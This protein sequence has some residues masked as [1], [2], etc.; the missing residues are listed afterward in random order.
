MRRILRRARLVAETILD[1]L[2]TT[3]RM[4]R[5]HSAARRRRYQG[6]RLG[7]RLGAVRLV[8]RIVRALGIPW[9]CRRTAFTIYRALAREGT[10]ARLC[11]GI[12]KSRPPGRPYQGHVW[13]AREPRPDV[14]AGG[15]DFPMVIRY[16]S[17]R[18]NPGWRRG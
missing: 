6:T 11:F 5:T 3:F 17:D 8:L 15:A 13:V 2:T 16:P 4:P 7:E 9:S 14:G 1:G 10:P 12:R 18:V